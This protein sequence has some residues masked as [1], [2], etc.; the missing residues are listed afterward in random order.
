MQKLG[1]K[2]VTGVSRVTIKKSKNVRARSSRT[3]AR[4]DQ[5]RSEQHGASRS[6]QGSSGG[7]R[8]G[9]KLEQQRRHGCSRRPTLTALHTDHSGGRASRATREGARERLHLA[10]RLDQGARP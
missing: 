6:L 5:A 1:M 8:G 2:P 3:F 10:R 9:W 7:G 4:S